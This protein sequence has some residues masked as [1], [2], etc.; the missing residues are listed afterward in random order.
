MK[1]FISIIITL[2]IF[3]LILLI[4]LDASTI[5]H[6]ARLILGLITLAFSIYLGFDY[7]ERD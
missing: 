6:T 2:N 4:K 7:E 1:L 3:N 5:E